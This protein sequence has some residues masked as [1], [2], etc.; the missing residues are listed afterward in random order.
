LLPRALQHGST[1]VKIG[2]WYNST[3]MNA[4]GFV[5][6]GGK[7]SRMGQDKAWLRIRGVP[8]IEIVINALRPVTSTVAI[9][10]NKPEY[11]RLGLPIFADTNFGIGPIEAIRTALANSATERVLVAGCDLPFVTPDL[12][13]FLLA[14]LGNPEDGYDAV[15]PLD[16]EGRLEPLC[17]AYSTNALDAVAALIDSGQRKP[18]TI[19]DRV[20]T[21]I[22]PFAEIEHL[23]G[24]DLFFRNVNTPEDFAWAGGGV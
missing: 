7:S 6:A 19:Y 16:P 21:R 24:S 18:S 22:V 17:A 9:I 15:V 4:T 13:A 23:H 8:M 3:L 5:T 14:G 10:A 20:K 11:A 12:F 1:A 2:A